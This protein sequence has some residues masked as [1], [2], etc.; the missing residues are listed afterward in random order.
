[1]N[2][3]NEN[4]IMKYVTALFSL[5]LMFIMAACSCRTCDESKIIHISPK[6]AENAREFIEAYTGQEFYEKFIV[7]DKI[8]TEYNNKNYKLVYVI[9]IP[10]KTFFR[11]EISFYMDS[12]GTVNTNLPVS[13][14]P[15]C[16]D[17]PGD[18][19]FAIDETMAREIAKANSFEKG[20]K[21]WMVSVVW[22]DQYQKYVW[23]I[24]STI[25]ESQ[26]SNG[27]IGEGHYLI[28]DINNGKI[29]EKN[30]W[31]VR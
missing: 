9:M 28:I 8:K 7:L 27:F 17:N 12:S 29:L 22:N 26:G 5:G 18:C 21:D 15:N 6:M 23:Y 2:F 14:I 31:K 13:G 4:R 1:M 16:L 20:I 3:G 11:G 10:E 24:L 19:D 30:N 25:Y